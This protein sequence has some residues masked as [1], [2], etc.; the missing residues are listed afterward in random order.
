MFIRHRQ[1]GRS[2]V[3]KKTMRPPKEFFVYI[4][5]NGPKPAVLYTGITGNLSHRVRQH[6]NKLTPG[7]TS[8]YK[9]TCL[10]YY[11]RFFYPDAAISREKEIKGWRRSKRIK[12]IESINPRWEDLARDCADVFKPEPAAGQRE[13]RRPAGENA[14]FGMTPLITGKHFF[15]MTRDQSVET[16]SNHGS[17]GM[18]TKLSVPDRMAI[19]LQPCAQS[20]QSCRM[21]SATGAF[22]PAASNA[23]VRKPRYR[24]LR[25]HSQ[26]E[27][28]S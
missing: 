4:M 19:R 3:K 24:I 12:L 6:K 13:I 9:L 8:R 25:S 14:G 22:F 23:R 7:F 10:V 26:Q 16:P 2:C 15:N 1:S 28:D 20:S 11:E 5:T 17:P 21:S 18:Q 27:A